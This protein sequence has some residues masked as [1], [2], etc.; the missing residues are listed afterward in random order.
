MHSMEEEL[1][2][3]LLKDNMATILKSIGGFSGDGKENI[4]NWVAGIEAIGRPLEI[5]EKTIVKAIILS[6]RLKAKTWGISFIGSDIELN[7]ER[8]K[9]GLISRFS[10]TRESDETLARFLNTYEAK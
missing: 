9:E 1:L 8:L 2:N 4:I 6:L 10:N 5:D 7:W 3:N